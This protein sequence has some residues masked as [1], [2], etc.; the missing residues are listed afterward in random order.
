MMRIPFSDG[1]GELDRYEDFR[2]A[3]IQTRHVDV[4]Y[5]RLYEEHPEYRFPVVYMHDGQN[6]F[7]PGIAFG[8]VDWGMD[9][10]VESLIEEGYSPGMIVVGIWNT[11]QRYREYMPRKP[12]FASRD[13]TVLQHLQQRLGDLPSSDDYL[14]FLVGELKPFIDSHYRTLP[15]QD[16]TFVMGSSMG[17]LVSAYAI[18][19]YPEVFG[20]AGCLSS[21]WPFGEGIL[22]EYFGHALPRAGK[23]K[24]Y[25]DFGTEGLD[26]D[27]EPYQQ[28]LDQYVT[29]L[30]Y[31]YGVDWITEKFEGAE[32]SEGAWRE[33]VHLPL[34][35]FLS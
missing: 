5:P 12:L 1:T 18:S 19:E 29:D 7:D 20:G 31:N 16:H 8:G 14:R 34:R 9:E 35:L 30:G 25:F 33:R 28:A 6:L 15:D 22:A 11:P 2:S 24:L 27:Y 10:T 23:H 32:H 21:H 3:C 17:G 26:A 4:W 13:Q